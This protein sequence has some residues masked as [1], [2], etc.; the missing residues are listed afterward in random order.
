[1]NKNYQLTAVFTE[2]NEPPSMLIPPELLIPIAVGGGLAGT[3]GRI[4]LYRRT[5]PKPKQE[6]TKKDKKTEKKE[7]FSLS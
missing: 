4:K 5:H 3:V 6:T 7:R 1:M 2:I